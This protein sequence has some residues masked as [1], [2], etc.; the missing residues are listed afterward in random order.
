MISTMNHN[1]GTHVNI[2]LCTSVA[3]QII[4]EEIIIYSKLHCP[5]GRLSLN[6][7]ESYL[8]KRTIYPF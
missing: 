8:L 4:K 3:I 1:K 2:H 5:K 6:G 7:N